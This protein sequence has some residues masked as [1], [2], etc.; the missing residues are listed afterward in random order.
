[1]STTYACDHTGCGMGPFLTCDAARKHRYRYH[2]VPIP[3]MINDHEYIVRQCDGGY[4][5]PFSGCNMIFK[6][7]ENMQTHVTED[8]NSSA[9]IKVFDTPDFVMASKQVLDQHGV[10]YEGIVVEGATNIS[11]DI[12]VPELSSCQDVANRD[13]PPDADCRTVSLLSSVDYLR[14]NE[15]L[16]ALGVCLH[17]RL[18]I[19]ICYSCRVALTS[20]MISGH[21]KNRHKSYRVPPDALQSF[22]DYCLEANV[23][24]KPEH[25]K[26]PTAGGPPVQQIADPIDGFACTASSDCA[27]A[28]KDLFTMQRHGRETHGATGL[29]EI[30][31]RSCQVQRIFSSVGNSYFEIGNNF[32]PSARPDVRSAL[33]ATFIPAVEHSLVVPANT[34]RERTPLMRFMGWDKFQVDLRMNPTQ[35]RAAEQIKKKHTDDEFGGIITC[36]SNAVRDHM[37]RASSILDG[38][39]H[40]LS[41]SKLLVYGDSIPRET[42]SHWRPVSDEN[43]EYPNFMIQFM[44]A[45]MRIHLGF[46]F[47]F[48]FELSAVQTLCLEELVLVLR[49]KNATPRKRMIF[50]HNFSWS[51]VDTDP[52]LCLGE[53][54]ANPIKRAIWLRALRADG[55]FCEA[56]VLTPDLAKFKYLCNI[57]SLLEALMDKDQ[58]TDSV[59]SDDHDR[60]A[61]VHERVLRLGRTTTFNIVYEMQQY[62]SSL[63]FNQTREPNVYVDPDVQ[64]ITIGI[65]TMQMD[66]LRSGIQRLL[67]ESKSRYSALTNDTV[68]LKIVEQVKD[69]L[70]NSTRGY[71][72]ASEAPFFKN[73]HAL[74]FYL[75]DHY[76]LAIIDNAGR[77][78][79]NIPEIKDLLRRSSR[80]WEPIYH[81]LYIT[82][83]ISCRGTQFIDHKIT[84]KTGI[85][86]RDSCTPGFV[87][88]DIALL[89]LNMIAGGFRTAEAILA[90]VAYGADA[91]HLY[92]TYL[93][94]GEGER[95]SP[96]QFSAN[97]QQW[98]HNY[99]DCRWGVR[100]FR[101]GAITIGRE[102]IAPDDSYDQAD[103]ILAESADHSTGMDHSHYAVIQGVVPRL[104]NN[105][106][107]KHRWL[108]DQWHSVLGLGPFPPPEAIR[109]SRKNKSD[110]TTLRS[111]ADIVRKTTQDTIK[112]FLDAHHA[113]ILKDAVTLP[114]YSNT[115]RRL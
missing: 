57:T 92:R 46:P 5:C 60:V 94:V 52:S 97:I 95:I 71:S 54:W 93:C 18:K 44:R 103:N 62:A 83:H 49:D 4:A 35:R 113:K 89:V 11:S 76:N 73:R 28:V 80:V 16:D 19:L 10:V 15:V 38:H 106:M 79:W 45:I 70:T 104:S 8:H 63:V 90:G 34:E 91:E 3:F 53:R 100:D 77:L 105:S 96:I 17:S 24:E 59:H 37:A 115:E 98:N 6:K 43:I 74:F 56:S 107:C 68:V 87:P 112:E 66:K 72:L 99:F 69:D 101:Q 36:L 13:D 108:G 40:R 88:K 32:V 14:S 42:D 61:R 9:K 12:L 102:F 114:Q 55:N 22:L 47:D 78:A 30:H 29:M 33:Q 26:L 39:P 21:R 82:T 20:G 27:Y 50:Y 23:Y 51:L 7:R 64:S 65:H 2:S 41:L 110:G 85:T 81:L 86:D 1:M 84:K 75:V 109:I 111:I 25:V 58:D 67:Q 31:H 48:S